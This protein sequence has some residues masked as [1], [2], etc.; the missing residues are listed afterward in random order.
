[1]QFELQDNLLGD[2]M[3]VGHCLNIV[4]AICLNELLD[5]S[6]CTRVYSIALNQL[7]HIAIAH[8]MAS[9]ARVA[10]VERVAD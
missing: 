10:S 1:M 2:N 3:S 8:S 6:N 4:W 9:S 5:R 7:I